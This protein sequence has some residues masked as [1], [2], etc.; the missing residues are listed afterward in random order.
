MNSSAKAGLSR[1]LPATEWLTGAD[2]RR[3]AT[4]YYAAQGP[5]LNVLVSHGF[6]EHRGWWHHVAEALRAQGVNVLTYDQYGHGASDGANGDIPGYDGFTSGLRLALEQGVQP[7]G[8]GLPIVI[9]GHSNGGLI[10]L[11][12]LREV[13]AQVSGL[14]LCSP[15]L[16]VPWRTALPGW[17]VAK[18][19]ALRDPAAFWPVKVRPWRLTH[20]RPIWH[21]YEQDPLRF[22]RISARF[23][24]AMVAASRRAARAVSCE[25][26]PLLLLSAGEDVVVSRPAMAGWFQRAR[27]ADKQRIH[28]PH[29]RHELFNEA[30]WTLVL[31]DVLKWLNA[32]FRAQ[33]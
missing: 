16:G 2:G 31:D 26:V 19:L 24:L 30:N 14:V 27:S 33:R 1:E 7:R 9:L 21:E 5:W 18:L 12:A 11:L 4:S 22:H 20:N 15:L 17:P 10:A 3:L 29:A 32:R 23:F 28:Y 8:G 13:A 25:G 6:A